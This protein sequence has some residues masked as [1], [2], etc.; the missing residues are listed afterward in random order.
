MT[1][2][3]QE[4]EG[5]REH[6]V[7]A[8]IAAYQISPFRGSEPGNGWHLTS[9]LASRGVN[10]H[11]VTADRWRVEIETEENGP[12]DGLTFH[13]IKSRPLP[14]GLRSGRRSVYAEYLRWQRDCFLVSQKLDAEE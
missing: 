10:V 2:W 1:K 8:L 3:D 11:V 13:Y 4:V 9:A 12:R 5:G 14:K 6:S 7:K